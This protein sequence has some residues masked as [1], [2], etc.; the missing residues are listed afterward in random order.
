MG[1]DEVPPPDATPAESPAPG[2]LDGVPW[3]QHP[4]VPVAVL[5]SG[6]SLLI[7]FPATLNM[8]E[9]WDRPIEGLV[10]WMIA[11]LLGALPVGLAAGVLAAR[12]E[13]AATGWRHPQ[14]GL[15]VAFGL[16]ASL[17]VHWALHLL[18]SPMLF[19]SG[20]G[21]GSRTQ[22]AGSVLALLAWVFV[23]LGLGL[24]ASAWARL[25]RRTAE[26]VPGRDGPRRVPRLDTAWVAALSYAPFALPL[27]LL[28][29]LLSIEV[30]IATGTGAW[31]VFG[32][33]LLGLSS[34][35]ATALYGRLP[36]ARGPHHPTRR[37]GELFG[38]LLSVHWGLVL[39]LVLLPGW[40]SHLRADRL[41]FA[42]TAA[43]LLTGAV[44]LWGVSRARR[45]A[46]R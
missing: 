5:L 34:L 19:V 18:W 2:L 13:R 36:H 22:L 39:V 14:R 16:G 26:G 28:G 29:T 30:D 23:G 43:L 8:S 4:V 41:A 42:I 11:T 45:L 6:W 17:V 10:L 9:T 25:T 32:L 31:F 24:A 35:G 1:E 20:L 21:R 27:G 3:S 44:A 33:V 40:S 15:W 38:A 12:L 37:M 7:G 46:L